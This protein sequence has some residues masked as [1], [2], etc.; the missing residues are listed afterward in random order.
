M[1]QQDQQLTSLPKA[2]TKHLKGDDSV[3]A[4]IPR[5]V[6]DAVLAEAADSFKDRSQP[7]KK[8]RLLPFAAAATV[9]LAIIAGQTFFAPNTDVMLSDDIDGSGEV[10]VLDAFAL[11]RLQ[12]TDDSITEHRIEA[13]LARIV[14]LSDLEPST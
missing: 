14:S 5:R 10:D 3:V 13:L 6:D 8:R 2:L 9:L 11:A 4:F 12:K 1:S 7:E